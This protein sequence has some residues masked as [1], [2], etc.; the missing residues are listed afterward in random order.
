MDQRRPRAI[1]IIAVLMVLFGSAE[2][3]T[4]F[5]HN[6][7]GLIST[8]NNSLATYG[9]AGVGAL[10]AVGGFLLLR[11]TK[12]AAALAL[13]CLIAVVLGRV[14]L[15]STGLYPLNTFLQIFSIVVGTLIAVAFA[16]YIAAKWHS[17]K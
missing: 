5:T 10:Y 1:T 11:T 14:A 12:R 7:L 3:V 13:A 8:T 15:V 17:F 4:G 16:I 2:V 6:F 9:A